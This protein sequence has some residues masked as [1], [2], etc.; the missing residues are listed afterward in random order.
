MSTQCILYGRLSV[1]AFVSSDY[2]KCKYQDVPAVLAF[3][4]FFFCF[5][6]L[7]F[8]FLIAAVSRIKIHLCVSD[9]VTCVWNWCKIILNV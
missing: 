3:F 7:F 6:F 2:V 5:V 1:P 4:F 8:F 9:L